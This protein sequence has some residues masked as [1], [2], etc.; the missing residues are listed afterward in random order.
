META[1]PV[2]AMIMAAFALG[3][4]AGRWDDH[5]CVDCG[6]LQSQHFDKRWCSECACSGRGIHAS[7][8]GVRITFAS[9][10]SE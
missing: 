2:M 7:K 10:P 5:R 8:P 1:V 9:G 3:F 4:L 6:H